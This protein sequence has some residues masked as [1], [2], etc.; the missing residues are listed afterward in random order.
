[1]S[2]K[3]I[4][5]ISLVL[6]LGAT[7]RVSGGL[8][9]HWAF[10][11]GA[12]TTAQDSSGNNYDG[13][14]V[15]NPDWTNDAIVGGALHLD[16]STYVVVAD[17]IGEFETFSVALWFKYDSFIVDWNS[18]WH[19][20]GWTGGWLHH[21]VANYAGQDVRVQFAVN[22]AGDQ[23]GVTPIETGVWYHSTVT[24]DSTTGQMN[25][26]L[27]TDQERQANLDAAVTVSGPAVTITA[28]QIGGWEGGRLSSAT[29]DDLRMYDRILSAAKIE[30]LVNGIPPA[31]V[32]A[33]APDPPDGATGWA[34]PL[35]S[36][37]PGE[38]A[39]WH[40]VYLG[41]N[42]TPGAAQYKGRQIL[43]W[44]MWFEMGGWIPGQTYYWRIDEVEADGTTIH[45]GDVWS[46]TAV[47]MTALNPDPADGAKWVPVDAVLS[48]LPGATAFTHDVYFG[49]DET[50]VTNGTGGTFKANQPGTTYA[51]GTL[52]QETTYY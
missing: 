31:W 49:T 11:D 36:W 18:F 50:A 47:G 25:F 10:D 22:G 37:Q 20:N 41:T 16:G 17:N 19:N 43:A 1:M 8:V 52:A 44:S 21:M 42:P 51:P 45:V 29:F 2:K 38:T 33:E 35:L 14:I 39:K 48:W 40:D 13:T 23:F 24:Y 12:G 27:T 5:L 7:G 4:Y 15:G 9:A 6:V 3:L 30:D 28:G 34:S 46:F 32:K 26:Y